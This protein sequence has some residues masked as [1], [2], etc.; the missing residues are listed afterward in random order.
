MTPGL[1]DN[2]IILLPIVVGKTFLSL[3]LF[4]GD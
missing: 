3:T 2:L 1:H 4:N